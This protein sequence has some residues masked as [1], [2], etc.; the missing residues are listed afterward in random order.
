MSFWQDIIKFTSLSIL[1]YSILPNVQG[2]TKIVRVSK[3]LSYWVFNNTNLWEIVKIVQFIESFLFF[4]DRDKTK[5]SNIKR[6]R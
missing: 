1:L 5:I 4:S 2:T 6:V 3:Y